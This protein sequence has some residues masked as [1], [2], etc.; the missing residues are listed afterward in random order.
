MQINVG[1]I[2][3]NLHLAERCGYHMGAVLLGRDVL[4]AERFLLYMVEDVVVGDIDE[5]FAI[6]G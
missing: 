3:S 2:A 5:L 1:A 6:G 4:D